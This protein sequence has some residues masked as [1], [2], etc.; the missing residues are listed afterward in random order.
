MTAEWRHVTA[1]F[2]GF[3]ANL[4]PPPERRWAARKAAAGVAMCLR[5]HFH[6]GD[7]FPAADPSG[8]GPGDY[9]VIGGHG[10]GTAIRP[11][12]MADKLTVDMLYVLPA[13]SR[14]HGGPGED[15]GPPPLVQDLAAVLRA[16]YAA[17]DVAGE[18]WIACA[19]GAIGHGTAVRVIP[20]FPCGD[21]G[22]LLAA[23]GAGWRHA[24]PLAEAARL[25]LADRV[26]ANKATHLIVMAKAWRQAH[27]VPMGG[28]ALELLACE[29]AG[30]WT[31]QRRSLLFYDWMVRDFFFWL[32]LQGRRALPV[33][34]AMET[35]HA[36]DGWP[37]DAAAAYTTARRACRLERDNRDDDAREHWVDIFGPAFADAPGGARPDTSL[38]GAAPWRAPPPPLVPSPESPSAPS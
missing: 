24:N 19:G 30:L 32:G 34:G 23:P 13:A 21:G 3:I 25:R 9:V 31:Y 33:P 4:R 16:R 22:F 26:S 27:G 11:R 6:S 1:R 35:V 2:H 14:P 15:A 7:G 12:R 29:F 10:K 18:G 38:P 8:A 17:V 5:R 36:G 28:L 37:D 20:C